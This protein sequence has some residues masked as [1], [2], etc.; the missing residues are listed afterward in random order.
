L[1]VQTWARIWLSF[2]QFSPRIILPELGLLSYHAGFLGGRLDGLEIV[3]IHG[4]DPIDSE[5]ELIRRIYFSI[6][7]KTVENVL[8]EFFSRFGEDLEFSIVERKF[9]VGDGIRFPVIQTADI[10]LSP[11][12]QHEH[13]LKSYLTLFALE[14]HLFHDS[15]TIWKE[16]LSGQ[17]SYYLPWSDPITHR[18]SMNVQEQEVFFKEIIVSNW[19]RGRLVSDLR[20]ITNVIFRHLGKL[21]RKPNKK[22]NQLILPMEVM[23]ST[24]S[25][26]IVEIVESYREFL[27]PK[28]RA[29]EMIQGKDRDS[30]LLVNAENLAKAL[31][32]RQIRSSYFQY[33]RGGL[34]S[35]PRHEDKTPSMFVYLESGH[36]HCFSCGWHGKVY[37][38]SWNGQPLVFTEK[39]LPRKIKDI[40]VPPEHSKLMERAQHYLQ[41]AFRG[42]PAEKYLRDQRALNPEI[43]FAYGTGYGD[44]NLVSHLLKDGFSQEELDKHK[45]QILNSRVTF[46]L[47]IFDKYSNFY[48]RHI[49]SKD[50]KEIH[51]KLPIDSSSLPTGAFNMD[52]LIKN[53]ERVIIIEAL[54]EKNIMAIIGLDN[55]GSIDAVTSS[56][57]ELSLA[58]D[59][60]IWGREKTI[61]I[62]ERLQK[63][64]FLGKIENFT[65]KFIQEHPEA[66]NFKDINAWWQDKNKK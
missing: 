41:K 46:P 60:D 4:R 27:D 8:A 47:K 58:L 9:A 52:V 18:I 34:I 25:H 39:K 15:P 51:R 21:G 32:R 53:P 40:V 28:T 13:Q 30:I 5:R 45:F 62:Y 57:K 2:D 6:K 55:V 49:F 63:Q 36:Y 20:G 50:K 38:N 65:A 16:T 17:V 10:D 1:T 11:I 33:P 61:K 3:K 23:Q 31:E 64:G 43:A 56:V 19:Q 42:S 66:Q 24:A 29:F 44:G 54:G 12:Q 22:Q 48:G 59:N 35:C 14:Q 37:G 26:S 7:Q